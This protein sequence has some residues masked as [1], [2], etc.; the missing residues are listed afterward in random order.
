MPVPVDEVKQDHV[1]S[2]PD[3][4]EW[5]KGVRKAAAKKSVYL[6]EVVLHAIAAESVA[7]QI[8]LFLIK[9]VLCANLLC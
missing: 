1:I 3:R 5:P 9:Y 6:I 7:C 8:P 4:A 2:N